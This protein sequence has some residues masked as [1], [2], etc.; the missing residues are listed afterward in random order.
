MSLLTWPSIGPVY[1]GT[2]NA[3]HFCHTISCVSVCVFHFYAIFMSVHSQI[4]QV[5]IKIIIINGLFIKLVFNTITK[6]QK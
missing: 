6:K 2:F 1:L 5:K 3:R 4:K